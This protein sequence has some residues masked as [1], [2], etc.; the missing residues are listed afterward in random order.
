M[1]KLGKTTT[2]FAALMIAMLTMGMS[3][4]LWKGE[5]FVS[6]TVDTGFIDMQILSVA[7]D[8]EGEKI[9]VGKDK[10]VGWTVV[11]IIDNKHIK[12]T[13]YNGYPCYEVYIHYTVLNAG[14]I[15]VHFAGLGPQ[16]PFA[17]DP[18]NYLW[19]ASFYDGKITVEGWNG[20]LEQIHPGQRGDYT[21]WVHVEQPSEQNAQ[22]SFIIEHVYTQWNE[23]Y[24]W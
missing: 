1:L 4:A 13:I 24:T 21:I 17:Y 18:V 23:D 12:V 2:L 10:H 14:T 9:D 11:E 3:Y 20:M 5:L 15:A 16:P 6:G 7:S 19:A 8:D 22:Y